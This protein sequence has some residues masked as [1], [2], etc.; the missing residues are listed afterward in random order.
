MTL[1]EGLSVLIEH[2]VPKYAF[3]LSNGTILKS[4]IA[5]ENLLKMTNVISNICE[6][7]KVGS[8]L[9]TGKLYIFR[10]TEYFFIFF[11]TDLDEKSIEHLLSD[12]NERFSVKIARSYSQT[13]KT[14]KS[15]IKGI[16]FSM[17]RAAGPEPLYW[18]PQ[19]LSEKDAFLV[20]MKTLLNLTGEI[21]GAHKEML[22]FQPFIQY[23]A[24]GIVFLFQ[25]PF[26]SARGKAFDSCIT[27]LADYNDRAIIYEKNKHLEML[28]KIFANQLSKK[29]QKHADETGEQINSKLFSDDFEDILK[30]LD[31]IVLEMDKSSEVMEQMMR[32]IKDLK[33]I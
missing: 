29:F 11:L 6:K 5:E 19:D 32:S 12:I 16:V 20:S 27:I 2:I 3:V 9:H 30:K 24:L 17:A 4:T 10:I 33:R 8:Y 23:N 14:F 22:S 31:G 25:I 1:L 26:N 7:L 13:P 18:I 21:E 28:L 15:I